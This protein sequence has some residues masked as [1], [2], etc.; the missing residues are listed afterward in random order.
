MKKRF[1]VSWF[2]LTKLANWQELN[3]ECVSY[4]KPTHTIA[5][6]LVLNTCTHPHMRTHTNMH[7]STH[8]HIHMHTCMH[9]GRQAEQNTHKK[10]LPIPQIIS[11]TFLLSTAEIDKQIHLHVHGLTN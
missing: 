1:N 11:V 4:A 6:V 7:A 3:G 9:A 10:Q 8:A 2:G 5:S